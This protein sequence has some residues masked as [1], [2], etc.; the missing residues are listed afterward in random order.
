M[1]V[2]A[3]GDSIAAGV[4][5]APVDGR[6]N[7]WSGRLASW[8]RGTHLNLAVPGARIGMVQSVQAPAAVLAGPDV[9][10]MS[11]GGNDVF[12]RRFQLSRFTEGLQGSIALIEAAGGRIVL[13]TVADWSS[14]W[15][16]P[17]RLRRAFRH[18]IESVNNVIRSAATH[19]D[20]MLIEREVEDPLQDRAFLHPDRVHLS[21][22]GYQR[23][24][25]LTAELLGMVHGRD[26][27][28]HEDPQP[29]RSARLHAQHVK[30]LLRRTPELAG[31]LIGGRT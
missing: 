10:L 26:R 11:V 18:R 5:D 8:C 2:V 12:D 25:D 31:L 16:M 23:L 27:H 4:G 3:I 1:K 9:V 14:A 13:L 28:P 6:V 17:G 15:P 20:A 21:P 22:Q 29:S 7:A 24:A 19:C 30:P